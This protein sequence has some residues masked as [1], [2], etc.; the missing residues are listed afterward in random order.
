MALRQEELY[1]TPTGVVLRFP[2]GAVRARARRQ[3]ILRRLGLAAMAVLI[4]A[5]VVIATGPRGS[6]VASRGGT[7]EAVVVQPGQTL[8]E[9]AESYAAPSVDLR[10]YVDAVVDING[11][12][13]SVQAGEHLE[14]PG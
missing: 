6:A 3:E 4:V 2:T 1:A 14:L 5:V 8:W 13:G 12:E 7:P 11:I 10:A 9:I